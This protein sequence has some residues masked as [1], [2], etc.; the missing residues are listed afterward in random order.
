MTSMWY[1]LDYELKED[2]P[3]H[4]LKGEL[5]RGFCEHLK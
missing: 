2:A 1:K 3:Y 5:W 4:A